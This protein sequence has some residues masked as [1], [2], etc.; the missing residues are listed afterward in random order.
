MKRFHSVDPL[1]VPTP[2]FDAPV[3]QQSAPVDCRLYTDVSDG[4]IYRLYWFNCFNLYCT[5]QTDWI[6]SNKLPISALTVLQV[7]TMH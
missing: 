7:T 1:M 5:V 2:V 3:S 4:L 6:C